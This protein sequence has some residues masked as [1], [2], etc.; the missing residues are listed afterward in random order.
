MIAEGNTYLLISVVVPAYNAE[1]LIATSLQAII[2]QDYP[3]LEIIVVND[4]ST[5]GTETA[6]RRVLANCGRPFSVITHKK[7]A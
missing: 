6:A 1:M 2:A 5:D 4:A 3:N 7:T